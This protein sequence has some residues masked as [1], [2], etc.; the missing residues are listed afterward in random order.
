MVVLNA[1]EGTSCSSIQERGE[2]WQ[3]SPEWMPSNLQRF[4]FFFSPF[5]LDTVMLISS[6][7]KLIFIYINVYSEQR[8]TEITNSAE[9]NAAFKCAKPQGN[10]QQ[11]IIQGLS[12]IKPTQRSIIITQRFLIIFRG[13]SDRNNL[14]TRVN[15]TANHKN[16]RTSHRWVKSGGST[17]MVKVYTTRTV[18]KNDRSSK[19]LYYIV[20]PVQIFF[21]NRHIYINP[22]AFYSTKNDHTF[23]SSPASNDD[24]TL[25]DAPAPH[26]VPLPLADRRMLTGT[27]QPNARGTLLPPSPPEPQRGH[28]RT[29]N[30]H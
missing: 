13:E 21:I 23:A 3:G 19:L 18:K 11:D 28:T 25:R 6:R 26:S 10:L 9:N 12:E 15:L 17:G 20:T 2:H 1:Q 14:P 24:P 8:I 27:S 30:R 4:F 5:I 16:Y 29:R 22:S 7:R